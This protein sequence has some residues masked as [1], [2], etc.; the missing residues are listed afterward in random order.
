MTY[1]AGIDIGTSSS[2]AVIFDGKN[3]L[4]SSLIASGGNYRNSAENVMNE[5]LLRANLSM[6]DIPCIVATGNGAGTV[7]FSN[8]IV[9]DIT[10]D[11]RAVS[12]LLPSVRTVVDV[13]DLASKAFRVDNNGT[14]NS[15][16]FSGKCA[17][18][19]GR[20]L[21]VIARVLGI[22]LSQVGKLSLKSKKR[23]EFNTGCAVFMETEAVSRVAEGASKEDLLAGVHHALA[24]QIHSLAERVGIEEDYALVGG[25]AG[26]EGLVKALGE[27]SGLKINLPEDPQLVTAL[28]AAIMAGEFHM[29]KEDRM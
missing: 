15:F 7:P 3:I 22:E 13:G 20:V 23:I 16:V 27:V 19:S 12:F 10:C 2:K 6:D 11:G 29:E 26:D 24:S 17:G 14:I 25:G 28:G 21:Q 5:A 9:P 4:S 18:G 8:R 1:F